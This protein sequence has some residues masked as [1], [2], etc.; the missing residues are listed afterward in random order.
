MARVYPSEVTA[1]VTTTL[2]DSEV[3]EFIDDASLWVDNYLVGQPCVAE[4][5]LATIEKYL[6][7]HLISTASPGASGALT[8]AKRQDISESYAR[9][10]QG[11]T[12]RYIAVAAAFDACGIVEEHWVRTRPR[13]RALVGEGY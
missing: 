10:A 12:S 5:K 8:S 9:P 7:A 3:E 2:S 11:E 4:D 1:L 6:A 13:F